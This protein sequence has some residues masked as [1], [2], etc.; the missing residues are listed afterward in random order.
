M[1]L[2]TLGQ[3]GILSFPSSSA[4]SVSPSSSATKQNSQP[5]PSFLLQSSKTKDTNIAYFLTWIHSIILWSILYYMP[6]FFEGAQ[7]F[8][9]VLAGISALPQ[10]LTVVPCAAVVGVIAAKTGHYR[11]ALWFGWVLTTL[12]SGLLYLLS[13]T[14][15]IPAW[16]FLM[17]VSGI[18]IGLL[19]PAPALAIQASAPPKDIAIA[20]AMFTFFRCFGQTIGVAIGGVV[21]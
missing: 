10:S 15:T 16:I 5:I 1:A 8:T 9:P 2:C 19:F 3:A 18:G 20:A 12:G 6:L 17:L 11:W 7:D 4:C 21:F 13:P 14:I